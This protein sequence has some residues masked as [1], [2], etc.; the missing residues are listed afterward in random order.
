V[1]REEKGRGGGRG[2]G[3]Q[4]SGRRAQGLF[5]FRSVSS[6]SPPV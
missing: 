6:L 3:E 4:V 2:G 1:D 5:C